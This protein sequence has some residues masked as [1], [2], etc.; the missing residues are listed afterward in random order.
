MH[1]VLCS[2]EPPPPFLLTEARDVM[3][4][5]QLSDGPPI[6]RTEG[7]FPHSAS[8]T[9]RTSIDRPRTPSRVGGE[10]RK[11]RGIM[12]AAGSDGSAG[13]TSH[14]VELILRD[15]ANF[16]PWS[17]LATTES[18]RVLPLPSSPSPSPSGSGSGSSAGPHL[19]V[20]VPVVARHA[21]S[22]GNMHGGALATLVDVVTTA[23]ELGRVGG[24]R[25][26]VSV[27]LSVSYLT[28]AP[29]GST[30]V[31]EATVDRLGRS[32]VFTTARVYRLGSDGDGGRTLVATG[33]H[34]KKVIGGDN[35][36]REGGRRQRS[37]SG[38]GP[39]PGPRSRL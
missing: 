33:S 26:T 13:L 7:G 4:G 9:D 27:D 38:S 31:V 3:T 5:G 1:T 36:G 8:A 21:N 16:G 32:V 24:R 2:T 34:T 20:E 18:V 35:F 30:L 17:A 23:A 25:P 11:H 15:D 19:A 22:F 29:V 37:G 6:E 39:G 28:G 10:E 12:A 14:Q